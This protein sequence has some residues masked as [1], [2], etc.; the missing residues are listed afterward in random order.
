[1]STLS[2]DVLVNQPSVWNGN[3]S[4]VSVGYTDEESAAGTGFQSFDNFAIAG[5]GAI[6]QVS[7]LGVYTDQTLFLN[8]AP[9]TTTWDLDFYAN[10]SGA[11]GALMAST[12]LAAAGVTSQIL[13]TG[14]FGGATFNIYEFTA[15]VPEFDAAPGTEYWFSPFSHNPDETA[16]F[17]WIQGTGG[18]G[19][20]YQHRMVSGSVSGNFTLPVD[21]AFSLSNV[22]EPSTLVMVGLGII[23][24]AVASRRAPRVNT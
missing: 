4:N 21:L 12:S 18:D 8:K 13:G 24:A 17:I 15:D 9:N 20:G 7:W 22:P 3:G 6:N 19:A 10:N 1:V 14:S 5:G 16:K 2:A 11:P 23:L